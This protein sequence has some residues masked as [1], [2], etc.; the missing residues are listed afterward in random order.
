M[1][2]ESSLNDVERSVSEVQADAKSMQKIRIAH[3]VKN[4]KYNKCSNM[5]YMRTKQCDK[6]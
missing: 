3:L 2:Q 5:L 6:D 1:Q 4:I